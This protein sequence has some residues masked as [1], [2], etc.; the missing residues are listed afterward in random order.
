MT[1]DNYWHELVSYRMQDAFEMLRE[2][3][4]PFIFLYR[5]APFG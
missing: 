2:P 5:S 4:S 1:I 3:R